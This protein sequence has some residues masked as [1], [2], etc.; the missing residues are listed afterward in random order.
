MFYPAPV[1]AGHILPMIGVR[2]RLAKLLQVPLR[3][4]SFNVALAN[5]KLTVFGQSNSTR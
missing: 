3:Y 5:I 4:Q 2:R 1:E